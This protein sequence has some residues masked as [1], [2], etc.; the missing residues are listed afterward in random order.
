MSPVRS[1]LVVAL[2]ATLLLASLQVAV[3]ASTDAA[4]GS[5]PT[6]EVPPPPT[7]PKIVPPPVVKPAPDFNG[8]T[9]LPNDYEKG[10]IKLKVRV[11]LQ[12]SEVFA[13]HG[14]TGAYRHL[15]PAP[16]SQW[17][18]AVGIDRNYRVEVPIGREKALV[19]ALAKSVADF[20]WVH[21]VW[22]PNGAGA[23]LA[24]NDPKYTQGSQSY[25]GWINM[26][27]AWDRTVSSSAIVIAV[28]DSGLY[29]AHEDSGVWKQRD[30][31][32]YLTETAMPK[33]Q[34]TDSGCAFGH[35]TKVSTMAAAD[36]NQATPKGMAGTGFNSGVLPEKVLRSD[37][38]YGAT[39]LG[40]ITYDWPIRWATSQGAH[41]INMSY[42]IGT[43]LPPEMKEALAAAWSAGVTPIASAGN[44]N[45]DHRLQNRYPC[46]A[47]YVICV[48]AVQSSTGTKWSSSDYGP[49]FVDVMAPGYL[50]LGATNQSTSDYRVDSG[51]SYASPLTAGVFALLRSLGKSPD[52]QWGDI[53]AT[54]QYPGG[55][56]PNQ[57]SSYGLINAGAALWR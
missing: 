49:G 45:R 38:S 21:M 2:L 13:R 47:S 26:E 17:D 29:A 10:A 19:A 15:S 16:F 35:G 46:D 39:S 57:W 12:V 25:L 50:I 53:A 6:S 27:R 5:A 3:A 51:T 28:L 37:C 7:L 32:D 11:G 56:D 20:E 44:A 55:N 36:T 8:R 40:S 30:G 52:Q 18:L 22:L 42:D 48:G 41:I 43:Y 1:P 23:L 14:L 9:D 54:A 34:A 33:G 4:R 24:P 31:W